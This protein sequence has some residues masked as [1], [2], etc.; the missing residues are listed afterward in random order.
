M[1]LIVKSL[2]MGM[3]CALVSAGS[4]FGAQINLS[5][6]EMDLY[7]TIEVQ[8]Y[9]LESDSDDISDIILATA[10]L[11]IDVR[12]VKHVSGH[13]T[14]LHE[15]DDTDLE[16][17]QG[18]IRIDGEEKCPFYAEAGQLYLPFGNYESHFISD[19]LTLQLGETRESALVLGYSHSLFGVSIGIFNGEVNEEDE[20]D[21]MI[22]GFFANAVYTMPEKRDLALSTGLSLISNL[23]DSDGLT[24]QLSPAG[25][26]DMEIDDYVPAAAAFVNASWKE[27]L[28]GKFEYLRA[29]DEFE[30]D[31]LEFTSSDVEPW[32]LNIEVAYAV[33]DLLEVALRFGASD[34]ADGFLYESLH[35]A[36]A[37]FAPNDYVEVA[38]EFQHGEYEDGS[39]ETMAT[40]QLALGF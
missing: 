6:V 16:I 31:D 26:P 21:D 36:V 32:A 5:D 22:D 40:L 12:P 8:A 10:E 18:Y 3:V 24:D 30:S 17:D 2:A 35:G 37:T 25:A 1:N 19:P 13:I 9:V 38:L 4:V 15:E 7:G 28:F 33:T 20:D 27:K 39:D 14:L 23:G 34:D 29:L 11:G